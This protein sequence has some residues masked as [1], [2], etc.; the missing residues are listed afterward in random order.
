MAAISCC[1]AGGIG[2]VHAQ[3]AAVQ[4]FQ[5]TQISQ[6]QQTILT[7]LAVGATTPELY[8]GENADVGPQRILRLNPRPRYFDLLLDSQAFYT[9][10]ATFAT[11]PNVIGSLVFVN[12]LQA[13]FTPPEFKLGNG[14]I[15]SSVGL[16]SQWYNYE[17]SRVSALDFDA[18]TIFLGAKYTAGKWQVG[19]SANYT[20]LVNQAHYDNE[21][22][23][24]FLP[25]LGIQRI[26]PLGDKVLLAVGNQTDYHFSDTPNS[27]RGD[28]NDR[29]DDAVS[30]T[31][32]W[33]ITP[34]LILQPGYRL[35]FSH[36]LYN[37]ATTDDRNDYLQT[38]GVILLYN[39]NQAFSARAFFNYN[40]KQ[41]ND[42]L[43]P[44]YLEY[45][46]GLGLSLNL[47]F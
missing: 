30:V 23:H 46:G 2:F 6:Q 12:T 40:R 8:R 35:E 21:T 41:T 25:A 33:Q 24:E 1:L 14:K 5:N 15:S 38:A 4:Q 47:K 7:N 32:S 34:Q 42:A 43:T 31:L 11:D 19:L 27:L 20:R 29:F 13:A 44:A 17:N 22:Y 3:P 26:F 16:A 9:D 28:L 18:Q 37:T 36:Y 39:F 45:G 10:N